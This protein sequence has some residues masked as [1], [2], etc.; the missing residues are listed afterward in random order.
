MK[1]SI[2]AF[3][4]TAIMLPSLTLAQDAREANFQFKQANYQTALKYYLNAYKKDTNN[5]D[6]NYAI[7]VCKVR[8]NSASYDALKYLLKSEKKYGQ[9]LEFLIVM[10]QAYLFNYD[11][12]NAR[13]YL[14]LAEAKNKNSEDLA[15]LKVYID[16]A[17]QLMKKPVDVTFVNLGKG[18]NSEMDEETPMLTPDNGLLIY[19]TN[20]KFDT[21]LKLYTWDVMYSTSESGDFKKSKAATAINTMDDEY[22]A[23][24]SNNGEELYYRSDGEIAFEDLVVSAIENGTPK[25]KTVISSVVNSKKLEQGA[26]ST[27]NGDT[28]FFSS[29]GFGGFGGLDLFYS[30]KLPD[31]NW[32]QPVNM[33]NTVNSKYDESYP[34]LSPD[35]TKFYF[36]SNGT[37]SMGGFDVFVCNINP[38][39][40]E[41]D[42]PTNI[43]YPLNDVFDNKTISYS[44]DGYYAY[45]SAI[46]PDSY[47]YADIYRVVFNEKDPMVRM[48][49]V[50]LVTQ[51]GDQTADF[52]E[53][54]R[55]LKVTVFTKN[56]T[57]YGTYNYNPTAS[58][59]PVALLPGSYT[60][61]IEGETIEPFS[62]KINV[63]NA[64]GKP[65]ENIKAVVKPKK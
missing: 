38:V 31:G 22:L 17:E 53:T 48:Y 27:Q 61:E 56:K 20:N 45:V 41:M 15:L 55:N 54:E 9:E 34:M 1:K 10:S 21:G 4:A 35:G 26:F 14:S 32:S 51:Q 43:G 60:L 24:L 19:S 39:T 62:M 40:R 63:P 65:I 58:Q 50:K 25:G 46:K 44:A 47:G 29:D 23:G 42:E 57:I 28:L 3:I 18:I 8:T 49:L 13:K 33:G 12:E 7:G 6:Y 2:L 30:I 64:P 59:V 36:C 11:F 5:V 52:G 37:K 16:N